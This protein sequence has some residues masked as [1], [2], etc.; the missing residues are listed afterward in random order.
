MNTL[1][2]SG[3]QTYRQPLGTSVPGTEKAKETSKYLQVI[4]KKI[5][6]EPEW[7]KI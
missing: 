6:I 4:W 5:E 2:Q 3:A 1:F 7:Y